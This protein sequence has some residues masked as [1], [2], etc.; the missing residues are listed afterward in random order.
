GDRIEHASVAPDWAVEEMAR[1]GL[2]VV[3]Q[4]NFIAERGD[5][6]RGTVEPDALPYLYRLQAFQTA[7]VVLA[8]GSDAPFGDPDPWAAMRA[9]VTRQTR[10]GHVMGGDE[11]LSPEDA[12]GLFLADPVHLSVQRGIEVGSVADL[13]L[14]DRPW[15][16]A[17]GRLLAQDV[18]AVFIDGIEDAR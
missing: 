14:L 17:R 5:E 3:S 18:R 1:L 10:T 9:A 8:G 2:T 6:Y 11:A 16:S 13:C 4:P 15:A 12:L 7:G